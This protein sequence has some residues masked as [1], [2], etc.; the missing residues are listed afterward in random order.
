M[1]DRGT[2]PTEGSGSR[3]TSEQ[4]IPI[5]SCPPQSDVTAEFLHIGK[6]S[7][8]AKLLRSE[9]EKQ[10]LKIPR[11]I[12]NSSSLQNSSER[13]ENST[14][15]D[16][17]G[18]QSYRNHI[19]ISYTVVLAVTCLLGITGNGLVIWFG[20]FRMK[21]TV[22]LVWFLSLAV[23]DFIFALFLT[24]L[25]TFYVLRYWAFGSFMC[26]LYVFIY[27]FNK[28]VIALQ[29]AVLSVDRC[30]RVAFPQWCQN[31][32]TRRSARIVVLIIWIFSSP[33]SLIISFYS[34]TD[35]YFCHFLFPY[36]MNLHAIIRF[37]FFFLVPFLVTLC[38]YIGI[39]L[40]SLIKH[41][42]LCSRSVTVALAVSIIFLAC[43]CPHSVFL[44]EGIHPMN[45]YHGE[46]FIEISIYL[47]IIS[48]CI[49]P[50]IYVLAGWEVKDNF[51]SS[52]QAMLEKA[53]AEDD[54]YVGLSNREDRTVSL[55]LEGLSH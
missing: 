24:L 10:L 12:E 43:Y 49:N 55:N 34:F 41:V 51:C 27:Y 17:D 48:S 19:I 1:K 2:R 28:S 8:A 46:K 30:V 3:S 33:S 47:L 6:I 40:Y 4:E 25:I 38:S 5:V 14:I 42:P 39:T 52:F 7:G 11:T 9:K 31:H 18:K 35:N 32:R 50:I 29:L 22:S 23:A 44:S 53:F 36:I 21:K 26:Q 37:V 13:I 45:L 54:V 16:S 20:I 15:D